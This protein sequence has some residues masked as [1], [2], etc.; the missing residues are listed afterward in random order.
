MKVGFGA[1]YDC[2]TCWNHERNVFEAEM[3]LKTLEMDDI[4]N[5]RNPLKMR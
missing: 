3:M 5:Y 2:L 1:C 4:E